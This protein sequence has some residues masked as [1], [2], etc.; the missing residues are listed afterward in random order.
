MQQDAPLVASLTDPE[1]K[2][3]HHNECRLAPSSDSDGPECQQPTP[4]THIAHIDVSNAEEL[5]DVCR[6]STKRMLDGD[7]SQMQTFVNALIL[8][9]KVDCPDS[10]ES[11]AIIRHVSGRAFDVLHDMKQ[12]VESL[13][14]SDHQMVQI[15]GQ[16]QSVRS[17]R[18]FF[19]GCLCCS[20]CYGP[21]FCVGVVSSYLQSYVHDGVLIVLFS[22]FV[23]GW[24]R[25][26]L[27]LIVMGVGNRLARSSVSS[28]IDGI[29]VW[30]FVALNARLR[31]TKTI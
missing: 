27:C 29:L 15:S 2:I 3:E 7:I 21:S 12:N 26:L 11:D 20:G 10:N 19:L 25:S 14:N 16:S 18:F 6:I 4:A 5:R 1:Q 30:F 31:K 23:Y 17:A 24:T 8:Y 9:F 28:Y 13:E 22:A